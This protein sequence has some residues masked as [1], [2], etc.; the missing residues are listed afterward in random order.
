MKIR[1]ILDSRHESKSGLFP[2]KLSISQKGVAALIPLG[3]NLQAQQ[4]DASAAKV[5]RHPNCTLINAS[6]LRTL[7]D[8]ESFL[9]GEVTHNKTA[10][11]IKKMVLEYLH[12]KEDE[13]ALFLSAFRSFMS[14]KAGRTLQI[15]QTTLNRILAFDGDAELLTLDNVSKDWL[16]RFDQFLAKEAPSANARNIHH[17]NIRAVFNFAIDEELTT[18]YPFRKFAIKAVPTAKRALTVEELRDL[19]S[20]P[21]D[22][23]TQEYLDMF[24][25][26]FFL[27]GINLVDLCQLRS[28]EGGRVNYYRSKTHKLYSIKVEQEAMELIEAYRGKS[29]L[30]SILDRYQ[31]YRNYTKRINI[32]LKKIG[33]VEV[34]AHGR[35]V[36]H[37]MFPQL[38][39]YTARHTWAT[40]AA[41]DLNAPFDII[42][43]ALGHASTTGAEVTSVYVDYDMRKV[44]ALNRAMIDWV[45]YKKKGAE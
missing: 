7:S 39:T 28:I 43:K 25:L 4:W 19:F 11:Q 42:S 15:Y 12:P 38:S 36:F 18:H 14:T 37:P 34:L 16:L 2:V 5:I 8:V 45:L 21:T 20:A 9:L 22:A 33:E 26:S 40:I 10:S 6:I 13:Q 30:L 44:D 27:I 1:L 35:K 24:K 3:V 23:S 31:D 32:G 17:R 41:N 29:H